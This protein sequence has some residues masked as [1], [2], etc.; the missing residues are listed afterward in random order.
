MVQSESLFLLA[1]F[2]S[3]MCWVGDTTGSQ[4]ALRL[5]DDGEEVVVGPSLPF[6]RLTDASFILP[7][8]L[9]RRLG[10]KVR[11]AGGER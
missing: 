3:G 1:L 8:T 7:T 6:L 11:L 4:R 9:L 10:V 5:D 2:S